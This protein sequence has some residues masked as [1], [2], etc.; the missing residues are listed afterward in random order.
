MRSARA[1]KFT[2]AHYQCVGMGGLKACV[3]FFKCHAG[4]EICELLV[5]LYILRLC[6]VHD[7][8]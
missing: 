4:I 6:I 1:F 8:Y 2:R 3:A 5:R 7:H